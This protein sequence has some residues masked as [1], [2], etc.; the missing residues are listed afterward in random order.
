MGFVRVADAP[1]GPEENRPGGEIGNYEQKVNRPLGERH[2]SPPSFAAHYSRRSFV[3]ASAVLLA[4]I[5]P[6]TA[7]L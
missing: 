7:Q 2:V 1:H 3:A 4:A 6:K 5:C